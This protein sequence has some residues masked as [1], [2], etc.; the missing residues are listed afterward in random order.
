MAASEGECWE[1]ESSSRWWSGKDRERLNQNE[2][3]MKKLPGNLSSSTQVRNIIK[4]DIGS[5]DMKH[6]GCRIL[7]RKKPCETPQVHKL[8]YF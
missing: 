2:G 6:S 4:G 7:G 1:Q 8:M 3:F 5:R